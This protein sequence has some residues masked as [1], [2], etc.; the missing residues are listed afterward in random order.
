[1]STTTLLAGALLAASLFAQAPT[2]RPRIT[3]AAH[4]AY[5]VSDLKQARAYYEDF[6][7]FQEAFALKNPDGSD[8]VV[9]I[10]INDYQFIELWQEAPRNHGYLHDVAFQTEDARGLLSWFAARAVKVS[11][12]VAKDVAGDLGF[13]VT[14]PFGFT[15]RLVQ[16]AADSWTARTKGKFMPETRPS[17]HI[18]HLG[19]LIGD[20]EVAAKFYGDNF[21]FAAEGDGSKRRIGDG[22]DRFELGFERKPPGPGRFHIK[23]HICLSAPDVPK[24]AAMLKAKPAAGSFKEIETHQLENG[25]HVAELYDPDGNRVE[26]MEPPVLTTK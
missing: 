7:G 1:M 20:K 4:M 12:A 18:D 24:L 6:L 11:D 25:K 13:D 21:G 26:V 2:E 8:H 9:F 14:D 17:T 10:K 22:P 16:Y 19:I 3:A 15:I 23:D 5:C